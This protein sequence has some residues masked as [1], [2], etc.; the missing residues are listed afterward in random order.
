MFFSGSAILERPGTALPD[1][2]IKNCGKNIDIS[3]NKILLSTSLA[4]HDFV[5]L[6]STRLRQGSILQKKFLFCDF[7]KKLINWRYCAF[8]II[9]HWNVTK[10]SER[11]RSNRGQCLVS[12]K[13]CIA[14]DFFYFF[15]SPCARFF[16]Y[17]MCSFFLFFFCWCW[18]N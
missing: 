8:L 15:T 9:T 17:V 4:L 13:I 7:C 12:P 14:I 11:H 6:V 5:R 16:S 3:R 10:L 18:F 1:I 2:G